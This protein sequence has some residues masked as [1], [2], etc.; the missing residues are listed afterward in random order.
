M[1]Q[2]LFVRRLLR[3]AVLSLCASSML[4]LPVPIQVSGQVTVTGRVITSDSTPVR[5]AFVA[6]RAPADTANR[7]TCL[8]DSGGWF[9]MTLTS[10]AAAGVLPERCALNDA[11]PNPFSNVISIPFEISGNAFVRLEIRDLLGGRMRTLVSD[12]ISGGR[13]T[14]QWNG[15]DDLGLEAPAGPYFAVLYAGSSA[16]VRKL[17][18]Y[19][20]GTTAH[21]RRG[22][23]GSLAP[24]DAGWISRYSQVGVFDV[25]DTVGSS[26]GFYS[27]YGRPVTIENDTAIVFVVSRK[28]DYNLIC[29]TYGK[30]VFIFDPVRWVVTDTIADLENYPTSLAISKDGDKLYVACHSFLQAE[31]FEGIYS[32]DL[33]TKTRRVIL[34]S[35]VASVHQHPDG[36]VYIVVYR[37]TGQPDSVRGYYLGIIDQSRDSIIIVDSIYIFR[38]VQRGQVAFNRQMLAFDPV[39]PYM[40]A[41]SKQLQLFKYNL[42]TK[43]VEKYFKP[44]VPSGNQGNFILSHD[45]KTVYYAGFYAL[46]L[47]NDSI[48][49][50]SFGSSQFHHYGSLALNKDGSRLY[51]TDPYWSMIYSTENCLVEYNAKSFE[52]TDSLFIGNYAATDAICVSPDGKYAFV[53]VPYSDTQVIHLSIKTITNIPIGF[54]ISMTLGKRR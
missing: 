30:D 41:Y 44:R 7:L 12:Y 37:G 8:T 53:A 31:P 9:M 43:T 5:N 49:G 38:R 24:I 6:M 20:G 42:N 34:D 14:V 36:E 47:A 1:L 52:V 46:D 27:I 51:V 22:K 17:I 40:Y 50:G 4:L 32:I 18:R 19:E 33:Q 11:W 45:C 10:T 16:S 23:S 13:H 29:G 25:V 2:S 26:P 35:V 54:V 28:P 3:K 39:Q 15:M 48:L 21:N